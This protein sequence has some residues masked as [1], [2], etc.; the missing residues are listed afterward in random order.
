MLENVLGKFRSFS[1]LIHFSKIEKLEFLVVIVRVVR[2]CRY[3]VGE[4]NIE[5]NSESWK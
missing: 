1:F 4:Y 2:Y 5:N 3:H